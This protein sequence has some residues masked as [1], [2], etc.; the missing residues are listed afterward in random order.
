MYNQK[1]C[2]TTAMFALFLLGCGGGAND[3]ASANDPEPLNP[4]ATVT[5]S[6]LNVPTDT[7]SIIFGSASRRM[8]FGAQ[9]HLSD[10]G[11]VADLTGEGVWIEIIDDFSSPHNTSIPIPSLQRSK[12]TVVSGTNPTSSS[13]LCKMSYL[14]NTSFTHGQLVSSIAG[15]TTP[16]QSITATLSVPASNSGCASSFYTSAPSSALTATLTVDPIPGV[17]S[18]ATV[19]RSPVDLS[20]SQNGTQTLADIQG[21]LQNSAGDA[22]SKAIGVINLSLG[23]EVD[24]VGKTYQEVVDALAQFPIVGTVNTVITVAAGNSSQPCNQNNLNG[25][26]SMA[27]ALAIQDATKASTIVVGALT[28]PAASQTMADYSTRPGFLKDRFIWASGDSG[29]YPDAS[30]N[31][32][33]GTSFAAPR[34]AGVAA[35][36]KQKYPSLTS[37]QI[38]DAILQ[39]ASKDMNNDGKDDFTGVD[40]IF[41]NGK[42]SLTNALAF[43]AKLAASEP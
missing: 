37:A 24:G 3:L 27:V 43:A 18:K 2:L 21:H 17:A 31:L 9:A 7:G 29:F 22:G 4:N 26:N 13:V 28:G 36:L 33:Q 6:G 12:V 1:K 41:G 15:G 14:W 39:S 30:G 40:P 35:L 32:A 42:L 11:T 5:L 34:V 8:V 20:S 10:V 16:R 38:A 23:K 25:C 19:L